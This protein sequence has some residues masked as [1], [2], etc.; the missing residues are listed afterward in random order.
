VEFTPD[1]PGE[2]SF[3]CGMNMLRGKIIAQAG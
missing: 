2:F 3:T 1:R